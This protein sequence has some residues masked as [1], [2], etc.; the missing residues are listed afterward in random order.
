MV[1][2]RLF[3]NFVVH[4]CH[5]RAGEALDAVGAC[6]W[7]LQLMMEWKGVKG[8]EE[9]GGDGG[10]EGDD[11]SRAAWRAVSGVWWPVHWHRSGLAGRRALLRRAGQR[12]HHLRCQRGVGLGQRGDG[13][14]HRRAT[15]HARRA[16][17][18]AA[19]EARRAR[20]RRLGVVDP[21]AALRRGKLLLADVLGNHRVAVK[22]A[23]VHEHKRRLGLVGGLELD[24]H[25]TARSVGGGLR[26]HGAR[27]AGHHA[28]VLVALL[29]HVLAQVLALLRVAQVLHG[30]QALQQH[31]AR[32]HWAGRS[33]RGARHAGEAGHGHGWGARHRGG[34]R[35]GTGHS[36]ARLPDRRCG[37]VPGGRLHVALGAAHVD[38]AAAEVHLVQA[39]GRG[40][41]L[42]RAQLHKAKAAGGVQLAVDDGRVGLRVRHQ[43]GQRAV[44]E[45]AEHHLA[46]HADGE[47]AD[48]HL[49]LLLAG[50]LRVCSRHGGLLLR[51]QQLLRQQLLLH[52]LLLQLRHRVDLGH[53]H[54]GVLGGGIK[55]RLALGAA[56]HTAGMGSEWLGAACE[57]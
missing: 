50:L 24:I 38:A 53:V 19:R 8:A 6:T 32:G 51:G 35:R 9:K 30:D 43:R 44:E 41:Q 34:G 18:C 42:L 25:A 21:G 4:C 49:P 46:D 26:R 10:G 28:A 39:H 36:H 20:Q 48:V 22:L 27:D 11:N 47:V 15:C 52:L 57:E 14:V 16:G 17:Q 29:L 54:R 2:G 3:N 33:R 1:T 7:G 40:G 12:A 31:D 13:G 56:G 45:L 37:G 55:R 23:A 5:A